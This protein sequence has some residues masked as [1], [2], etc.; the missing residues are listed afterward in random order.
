MGTQNR[1]VVVVFQA[2]TTYN[3]KGR[4]FA[5]RFPEMGLTAYGDTAEEALRELKV[6]F[7][8]YIHE[9][10]REGLLETTLDRLGVV[11]HWR[12]EY[13]EDAL[14]LEDTNDLLAPKENS[15]LMVPAH[16][17]L[18]SAVSWSPVETSVSEANADLAA[19]A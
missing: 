3:E 7:N 16:Q 13:P 12:D 5:S 10:R 6:S 8:A 9:L 14:A 19:A 2:K 1:Q 18:E 4:L 11:W 17:V 15:P